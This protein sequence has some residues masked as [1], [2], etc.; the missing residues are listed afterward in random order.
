MSV[1]DSLLNNDLGMNSDNSDLNDGKV[2]ETPEANVGGSTGA[3]VENTIKE[4][5]CKKNVCKT[6]GTNSNRKRVFGLDVLR[7]FACYMVMQ[8]HA[9]EFYYIGEGSSLLGG[10]DILWVNIYGSLCRTSVPLFVMITGYFI[11]PVEEKLSVF[12]KKRFVRVVIPFLVWCVLYSFYLYF[13]GK[14]KLSVAFINILKIAINFG[15]EVGHLWY[16]YMLIGLYLFFPTIS[17]W[18]NVAS[19]RSL[20]FYLPFWVVSLGVPYIHLIYPEFLGEACWN[21]T[22]L[23][24][25]FSGFLGYAILAFY[26][27]KFLAEVKFICLLLV[28]VVLVGAGYAV[29]YLVFAARAKTVQT[30]CDVELSWGFE[31]VNV[32]MMTVGVFLLVKNIPESK[33][34]PL[35]AL[36][37]SISNLSYG[38]YL[39]HIMIL[40]AFYWLF[41]SPIKSAAA[42][43]PLIAVCCFVCS[44]L[45][46]LVVSFIPGS[47]YVI[48]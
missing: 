8:V 16:V 12:L 22:P 32:A 28:G 48:G 45:L 30:A 44:Y 15:N 11:L 24:Y 2:S 29:T 7:V 14:Y 47:K 4:N 20:Q 19:K 37:T 31:T 21:N 10:D 26:V 5:F 42:K 17:P 25:Y 34:K 27:R 40:N 3:N 46:T 9:G 43:I 23:L 13:L 39:L 35:N 41:N 1:Y 36:V 6:F 38:M 18:L 33:S